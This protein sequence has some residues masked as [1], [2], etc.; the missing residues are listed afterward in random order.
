MNHTVV[1]GICVKIFV[2]ISDYF[3]K[4]GFLEV[5]LYQEYEYFKNCSYLFLEIVSN[6]ASHFSEFHLNPWLR[7]I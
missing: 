2:Y 7:V 1:K 4:L 6:L 3:L 5:W